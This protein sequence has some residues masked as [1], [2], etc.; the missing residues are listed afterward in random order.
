MQ[1]KWVGVDQFQVAQSL[2]AAQRGQNDDPWPVAGLGNAA[3]TL[4][5]SSAPSISYNASTV[6]GSATN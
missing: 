4:T 2:L 3:Y 5:S 1:N 6:V